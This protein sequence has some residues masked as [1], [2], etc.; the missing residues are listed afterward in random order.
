MLSGRS[1]TSLLLLLLALV[2]ELTTADAHGHHGIVHIVT[3]H[4]LPWISDRPWLVALVAVLYGALVWW[5]Y[6]RLVRRESEE[7][8]LLAAQRAAL[9]RD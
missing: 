5:A 1:A 4:F 2:A 3:L 9:K 8:E 7:E 6:R